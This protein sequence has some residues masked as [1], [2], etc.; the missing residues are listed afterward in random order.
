LVGDDLMAV[1]L[2]TNIGKIADDVARALVRITAREESARLSLPLLY[3]GGSMV[4]VEISRLRD[5]FLVSD[6]GTA[7]RE[8][9][10]MGGERSLVQLAPAVATR[11]GVRFDHNMFF[12]VNV[13]RDELVVAVAA[14]ANAS[15]AAVEET[16]IRLAVVEHADHQAML[17]SKLEHLFAPKSVAR[18]LPFRGRHEQWEFDAAVNV[19]GKIAL[20]EIVTPYANSVNSAVTKFVDVKE[21]GTAAPNRVAILIN[22]DRT[23]HLSVLATTAKWIASNANDEAYLKAA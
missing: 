8:A 21:L 16:A 1:S 23:P 6:G 20:F 12:D 4:G 9:G 17:W 15:K 14:V 10:L 22:P 7:R 13:V 18:K 19:Q 2:E 5:G 11:Y 3:P